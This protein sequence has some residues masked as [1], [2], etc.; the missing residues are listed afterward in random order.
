[1]FSIIGIVVDTSMSH[2]ICSP[3]LGITSIG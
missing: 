1:M 3:S 2:I